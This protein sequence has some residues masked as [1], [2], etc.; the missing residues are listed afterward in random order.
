MSNEPTSEPW[1]P[2]FELR[3]ATKEDLVHIQ[4]IFKDGFRDDPACDYKHPKR[5][6][7]REDFE[8]WIKFIFGIYFDKPSKFTV[9]V[10]TAPAARTR[11]PISVSVWDLEP[12]AKA[13]SEG[14]L[15]TI[16]GVPTEADLPTDR[17]TGERRDANLKHIEAYN[18]AA[19]RGFRDH[20]S[21]HG[22]LHVNLQWL[23]THPGH[24]RLG[25]GTR[26]C[27]WGRAQ[28]LDMGKVLTVMAS[29]MG[30][31]LYEKLDYRVVGSVTAQVK[32]EE[33]N[34]VIYILEN[35]LLA[36]EG[37]NRLSA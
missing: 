5:E 1:L 32:G 2:E 34:V 35:L 7:Y 33:E 10:V 36:P 16:D 13:M 6:Q 8:N 15:Y 29:P 14:A 22:N 25:A 3:D 17:P 26:Q 30:K 11:R 18:E 4:W 19:A 37:T 20:F 21:Q 27:K 9:K 23:I 28:A 12:E 31:R 24:R